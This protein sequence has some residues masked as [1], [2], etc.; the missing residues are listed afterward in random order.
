MSLTKLNFQ[1][2]GSSRASEI[3]DSNDIVPNDIDPFSNLLEETKFEVYRSY[4]STTEIPYDREGAIQEAMKMLEVLSTLF[5]SIEL[6]RLR[7]VS[8]E[9]DMKRYLCLDH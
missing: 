8:W 6:G 2:G 9:D 4:N 7:R 5:E 3:S 1:L